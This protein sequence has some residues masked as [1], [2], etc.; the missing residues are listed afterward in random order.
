MNINFSSPGFESNSNFY[1]SDW[2]NYL[3]DFSWQAQATENYAPQCHEQHHPKYSQFDSQSS[4]HS[5][6]NQS[7]PQ[8]TLEDTLKAFLQITGK[9]IA[10]LEGQ[11]DY[12][13]AKLNR[14]EEE[15]L[16]SQL[17]ARWHYTI[18]EDEDESSNPHHEHAQATTTL[19]SEDV[20]KEI[21]NEPSLE[22]PLEESCAQ[23]EFDLDLDM[24]CEQAEALLDS[25]PEIR[26][27]NWETT[28]IS[29]PSSLAADEEEK[30]EHLESVK[31]LEQIEPPPAPNLSN[32]KEMSTETPPF[33]IVPLETHH[34]PQ[35]SVL[36]CLKEPFYARILKDL[37]TQGRNSRNHLP[38]DILRSKQ[39]GHL[40]GQNILPEG[41][42]ILKKKGWKGL[43]GHPNDRGKFGNFSFTFYFPH[44]FF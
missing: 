21:V 32:D 37:C 14:M 25:T 31:H 12:L 33:I 36:Q 1:N 10:K 3:F 44:I 27:K 20:V 2:S 17:M 15:E 42:Q 28:E 29:F 9:V 7:V 39:V 40:R 16:Q 34:E 19:E 6:Y 11:F 8:S 22:D 24:L 41:H 43:V 4:H 13:V 26:P 30:K 18:D 5:S 23:F 35:A 38:K